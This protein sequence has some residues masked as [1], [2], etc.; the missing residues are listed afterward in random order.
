MRTDVFPQFGRLPPEI[1]HLIW[2]HCLPRRIVEE[3]IP[4]TLLDGKRCR[5]ACWPVRTTYQNAR[6][7]VIASV[8]GEARRTAF[9]WGQHQESQD[10][11]SLNTNWLQPTI[12]TALHLNWTRRRNRAYYLVNDSYTLSYNETPLAM[13][14]YR[15]RWDHGMRISL[16]ADV[17]YPFDVAALMTDI[18]SS[19]D[20]PSPASGPVTDAAPEMIILDVKDEKELDVSDITTLA[21][22]QTLYL[23]VV[24]ISLHIDKTA[25]LASGLFGM[26]G[27][28]PV[29]TV[30]FDDLNRLHRFYELYDADA[31]AKA[32]EPHVAKLFNALFSP[33]FRRAV[34][35]WQRKASWMLQVAVWKNMQSSHPESFAGTEPSLVWKPPVPQGQPYMRM[36]EAMPDKELSWWT[37]HAEGQTPKIKLQIMI[38]LCDNQCYREDRR[39]ESF[40]DVSFGRRVQVEIETE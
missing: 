8:C 25:A 24:A 6:I 3:D 10:S 20:E 27:D 22:G 21:D 39:P 11:T 34:F 9:K 7:P 26:L 4:F 5:Q 37:E 38:R 31:N 2:F 28:A 29:Q 32:T 23:T 12:D 1:R 40:G 35:S 36:E 33:E 19:T 18:A 16:V 13:F 15:A 17:L 14:I 30:D